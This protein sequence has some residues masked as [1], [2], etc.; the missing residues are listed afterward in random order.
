[1]RLHL[2]PIEPFEQRYTRQW[3]DW[4]SNE[5]PNHF[6]EVHVYN[7]RQLRNTIQD[8]EFLDAEN[9]HF[10][11]ATQLARFIEK[12]ALVPLDENDVVLLLDGWSPQ[13][14]A[15]AYMRDVCKRPFKIVGLMH[16]GTYDPWDHLTICGCDHWGRG[17]ET[18]WFRAMDA[19]CVATHFHK[20]LIVS[21][22]EMGLFSDKIHVTGFPLNP[23]W[24]EC[25]TTWDERENIVVFPH[26]HAPE[27]NLGGWE[28]IKR[29]YRMTY[30]D[31]P[32]FIE[33]V[34]NCK[35]KSE[36]YQ[37]LGRSKVVV[38]TAFQETWG[39][40]MQE[41]MSLGCWPV[42]PDRLSY[43]ELMAI[44][45][46][47]TQGACELIHKCLASEEPY[48]YDVTEWGDAMENIAA[49]CHGTLQEAS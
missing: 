17:V 6:D 41:A 39:I 33:T 27:K 12:A 48:P 42:A 1:M 7:G 4:F 37:L 38:S 43:Q 19:I 3:Y 25:F 2:F 24:L 11:K 14:T 40:A 29:T 5:M 9:T 21:K 20:R 34:G 36:Y 13:V 10:W 35:T 47:T 15:L 44:R 22:R 8:G 30:P 45:Y 16:A 49:V 26:R 28:D 23:D 31:D 32:V 46:R 18:G